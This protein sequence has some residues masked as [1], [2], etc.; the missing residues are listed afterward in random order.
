MIKE[1][2][3]SSGGYNKSQTLKR[4]SK[5]MKQ[6]TDRIARRNRQIQ[7]CSQI[8]LYPSLKK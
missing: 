2:V 7:N 5:Y 8:F 6:K 4:V 1:G 3:N